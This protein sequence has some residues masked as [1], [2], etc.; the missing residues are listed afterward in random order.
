[1]K[2]ITAMVLC[3]LMIFSLVP[4][5]ITIPM[6]AEAATQSEPENKTALNKSGYEALGFTNLGLSEPGE[7]IFGPGGN[8]VMYEQKE[9][10]F[11]YNGSSNYGKVLRDN[12]NL[13]QNISPGD[14]EAAGAMYFYGQYRNDDWSHLNGGNGYTS[15]RLGG[16]NTFIE[17]NTNNVHQNLAYSTSVEFNNGSGKNDH[18]ARL[19]MYSNQK[20]SE[21][22]IVIEIYTYENNTETR[23]GGW[24]VSYADKTAKSLARAGEWRNHEFDSLIEVTA[25]DYDGDGKDEVAVYA[26]N[27]EIKIYKYNDSTNRL[28]TWKT[29][30]ASTLSANSG[31][32]KDADDELGSVEMAAVVTMAS[33]DLNKDYTDELAIAVS[34]PR[35]TAIDKFRSNNNLFVYSLN[36]GDAQ[37]AS[38][39]KQ[40]SKISL[41]DGTNSMD[42]ANV[43]IGDMTG[44]GHKELV[45]AGWKAEGNTDRSSTIMALHVEYKRSSKTYTANSFQTIELED[46]APDKKGSTALYNAPPGVAV[47]NMGG[48]TGATNRVY[49]FINNFLYNYNT[50]TKRYDQVS[51]GDI[52][53]LTEQRNNADEKTDKSET[54]ISKIV[55]GNFSG[56]DDGKEAL[57]AVIGQKESGGDAKEHWYYY[58][59][60]YIAPNGTDGFYKGCE[61][62]I[63]QA[64]SYIDRTDISRASVFLDLCSPNTDDDSLLL[65]YK[66]AEAY[67]TKPEVQAILQSAPYFQDVADSFDNYLDDGATGYG[68]SKGS[69]SGATA[70]VSAALGAYTETEVQLGGAGQFELEVRATVSYDHE[71]SLEVTTSREFMGNAGDDYVVMYTIPYYR[72]WYD[73]YEPSTG[74]TYEMKI[75][76][77]LTPATVIVPVETYDEIADNY[78]GLEKIRGNVLINTPG[79][80]YS[81]EEWP[82]D[83]FEAIGD[84]QM[85]TNA[86]AQSG[87]LVTVSRESVDSETNSFSVGVE[88]NLK[89]GA[90]GG[91]FG[92]KSVTG[93]S[94]SLSVAGGG[95]FSDMSGVAYTGSVDNLPSGVSGYGFNW[96]F[97][98][99]EIEFNGETVIVVG[100]QTSNVKSGPKAPK[101]LN[102]TDIGSTS[103]SLEWEGTDDASIYEVA[104]VTNNMELP[105]ATIPATDVEDDGMVR[106]TAYELSPNRQYTFRVTAANALGVRSVSGQDAVGTTLPENSGNFMITAQPSDTSAAPGHSATFEVAASSTNKGPIGYH[107]QYYD[108]TARVWTPVGTNSA[109]LSIV[110]NADMDGT[111]YR[112]VVYQGDYFLRTK[113]V[114]LT[115]NKSPTVTELTIK[116]K[117]DVLAE[118]SRVAANDIR[119][120]SGNVDVER[121][122][123][124]TTTIDGTTYTRY[125]TVSADDG[126]E[127]YV[128]SDYWLK[129]GTDSEFCKINGNTIAAVTSKL[130]YQHTYNSAK[131]DVDVEAVA[132]DEV[133]IKEAQGEGDSATAAVKSTS[134]YCSADGRK[135][136]IADDGKNYIYE[137]GTYSE[138]GSVAK[139]N[140]SEAT[141]YL[142][143]GTK[144]TE[145]SELV[146]YYKS[147][148][149]SET[150]YTQEAVDGDVITLIS[151]VSS[152]DG[153]VKESQVV[154]SITNKETGAVESV[155]GTLKNGQYTA[156]HTFSSPG[157][158]GIVAIYTGSDTYITS[159]SDE[160]IIYATGC[161]DELVLKGGTISYGDS[162]TLVPALLKSDGTVDTNITVE[163]TNVA[164]ENETVNGLINGNI[165]RP[166]KA[167]VYAITAKYDEMTVTTLVNVECKELLLRPNDVQTGV[168]D[169]DKASKMSVDVEDDILSSG[170][171]VLYSRA[172]SAKQVGE[173]PITI[174]LT[175]QGKS[176]TGG[177]YIVYSEPGTY[178]LTTESYEVSASAGSNGNVQITYS[179]D[180][181][182]SVT[183]SSGMRV[184]E[185]STVIL[186]AQPDAGYG[187]NNWTIEKGTPTSVEEKA[188][189]KTFE[190]I[191]G[192][193]L[194]KVTFGQVFNT[195]VYGS[196]N[197]S[198][199]TV[200]GKYTD[201]SMTFVS[202]DKINI[203]QSVTLTATPA[204]GYVLAKWTKKDYV[205]GKT[206][207]IKNNDG[208]NYTG[209]TV[210]VSGVNSQIE[211]TA[212]FEEKTALA[213]TFTVYDTRYSTNVSTASVYVNDQALQRADN[214]KFTYN[215]YAHENVKIKVVIPANMLVDNWVLNG[216]SAHNSVSE[217]SINDISGEYDFVINCI[218]PNGRKVTM[219]TALE[220][221]NGGTTHG[222]SFTAWRTS[223]TEVASGSEQPQGAEIVFTAS[224]ADGY[225]VN[226]IVSVDADGKETKL[227]DT[228]I[229]TYTQTLDVALTL[230]AYFEKKPVITYENATENGDITVQSGNET[231]ACGDYVEFGSEIQLNI[232]PDAGYIV[233]T[234]KMTSGGQSTDVPYEKAGGK[235]DAVTIAFA[236]GIT[237]D[238]DFVV[239]YKKK[240]VITIDSS[241]GGK[242]KALGTKDYDNQEIASGSYVDFGSNLVLTLTPDEGYYLYSVV[243]EGTELFKDSQEVY[244][245]GE[246]TVSYEPTDGISENTKINVVFKAKP[247]ITVNP[248]NVTVTPK[249][250]T[251][252][253]TTTWIEKY[254]NDLTFKIVPDDGY[255]VKSVVTSNNT[256]TKPESA[257]RNDN[258][259][260]SVTDVI[261][262]DVVINVS[263]DP[264]PTI[265]FKTTVEKIDEEGDG[266]HGTVAANV[267]RKE[268]DFHT[269]L[270]NADTESD[271][272][273]DSVISIEA[274]PEEGYRVQSWTVN[275][276]VQNET[277]STLVLNAADTNLEVVVRFIK[278]VAGV[279]FGPTDPADSE[280]YISQAVAGDVDQLANASTGVNLSEGA[281]IYF[282]ATPAVGYEIDYWM[283]NSAKAE[284]S[285]GLESYEYTSL[286]TSEN[287]YIEP[288]FVQIE[289]TV[290]AE[291]SNGTIAI[292]PSLTDNKA[293]GGDTLTFTVTPDS[294]YA[295]K[296]WRVNGEDVEGESGS[297][298]IWTVP[299]GA[300]ANPEVSE[301]EIQAVM[302]RGSYKIAYSSTDNG[303]VS[304]TTENGS[305]VASGTEVKVVANPAT[306]YHLDHWKVNGRK[307][308]VTESEI[309]VA[310]DVD[311]TVEAVFAIDLIAVTFKTEGN[312]GNLTAK[313]NGK[314]FSSGKTVEYGSEVV[315]T[316][317]PSGDDMISVWKVNGTPIDGTAMTDDA[318]APLTYTLGSITEGTEISVEFIDRPVYKV[319]AQAIGNGIVEI[320]G[321][322]DALGY[323]EV[324]RGEN[325]KITATAD[326]YYQIKAWSVNG[327][328]AGS[329]NVYV[330][331][332]VKKDTVVEAEFMEAVG[333]KVNFTLN[334]SSTASPDIKVL[335]NGV[336]IHP[337]S[338]DADAVSVIGGKSV[339]VKVEPVEIDSESAMMIK[340]WHI[341][342]TPVTDEN[343][344]DFGIVFDDGDISCGL[345][346]TKLLTNA[347][348]RLDIA[349]YEGIAIPA[350]GVGY[351]VKTISRTPSYTKPETE[352]VVGGDVEFKVVP[353][354]YMG[355]TKL[356]INGVDCLTLPQDGDVTAIA[357]GDGSYTIS[358][359]NVREINS[360]I[361]ALHNTHTVTIETPI[362]GSISV[363]YSGVSVISGMSVPA[364]TELTITAIPSDGFNIRILKINGENFTSGSTYTIVEDIVITSTFTR[365][366]SGG[367]GG[368]GGGGGSAATYTVKFETNG[369]SKI[370]NVK[371]AKNKLIEKPQ[372]P[373]RE[374]Y[375]FDGWYSDEQLQ[376]AYDF[377]TKVTK[378]ITLYAKWTEKS[379]GSQQEEWINPF[380]DVD[381]D[382]WF[383]ENVR[384]TNENSLMNGTSKTTFAPNAVITR[385]MLIT[386][387]YRAEGEPDIDKDSGDAGFEDV[388]SK[389]YYANAVVWGQ[390]NGIIKGYSE[391]EFAPDDNVTRE[392][393]AAI[394]HRYAQYKKYDVST[395]KDSNI[396][397]YDDYESISEYAIE[398][399]KYAVSNN[400][401]RGK[402]ESTLNPSDSATRAEVAA[403]LNRFIEANVQKAD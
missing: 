288:H 209:T 223:G 163:Y 208:T 91:L 257:D 6:R 88:E 13:Y 69:S 102:I 97:G 174:S 185:G 121:F 242:A 152:D 20:R 296:K 375:I 5:G 182:N 103:M 65:K 100:Y 141:L 193:I 39:F 90:G 387:I 312:S 116:N 15:G 318:D 115:I 94:Q 229:A 262:Q 101:N 236:D 85:L 188:S 391:T 320:A 383:Y 93:V 196:N 370:E 316:A 235:S 233:D 327:T 33:G 144:Y 171:Y 259:I 82:L 133:T 363:D 204:N 302:D 104:I 369:G 87:S 64:R 76:E 8:T 226:R 384:Y 286:G 149:V 277:S 240:P 180:G 16:S 63:N 161:S 402:T 338:T 164:C 225:R 19:K 92:N 398:S 153:T 98:I 68:T 377:N 136:Y 376:N 281:T 106:F 293:R 307:Q 52:E 308:Q 395:D 173:Y 289:Y 335:A 247:T 267:T 211:Y 72:Y 67:Y 53:F 285:E 1:M 7:D 287:V 221:T 4:Q 178:T 372:D 394:M 206:E 268:L 58:S 35:E 151:K 175:S 346:I 264:I 322:K 123:T 179:I 160:T 131:F 140:D 251:K 11:N 30:S 110:T 36:R 232:A 57:V 22:S 112:C 166:D 218:T 213:M 148:T 117:T 275:G 282:A 241:A 17:K 202:G 357:N 109:V 388:D 337:G 37:S 263:A 75:E 237:L 203:A 150:Q 344:A 61:G 143:D 361:E 227:T 362:N 310:V 3:V 73:A 298:L 295:V 157:V 306:G 355:I 256:T 95:V 24:Y 341:N 200:S 332:G 31:L 334:N 158:Y 360:E 353:D 83:N 380:D 303:S 194:A 323:V 270:I 300:A 356:T 122:V 239:T 291:V 54:W 138:F 401:L 9:L 325:V 99:S 25:G 368:G 331:A 59:I 279:S 142:K 385:A 224:P 330:V 305:Y 159:R 358:L 47:V 190:N 252:D 234:V 66:G 84:V 220:A 86:G 265:T 146:V 311:T 80:P 181:G 276:A 43:A 273:R 74:K 49:V 176:K 326:E 38:N 96:Q 343:A 324:K 340:Q 250:G 321:D 359:K 403:I 198:W 79:D 42:S 345:T 45:V 304:S 177:K 44:N 297:T 78:T 50:G 27:N 374:D 120:V 274:T 14:L 113:T 260:V 207:I 222:S 292:T 243:A 319:S 12:V 371:V 129:N 278:T 169:T 339:S 21:Q 245:G 167:G 301:Y 187:V 379:A 23:K 201:S 130:L 183:I 246:E 55:T 269:A 261:T 127:T 392:Q 329:E 124:E 284:G 400:I 350:D 156:E 28:S 128:A 197:D 393:I 108:E 189:T 155:N 314:S 137:N 336:Q 228:G 365:L 249:C 114:T 135:I 26:A 342:G 34:M 231:I 390:K 81:Y 119:T 2:R 266:Y 352:I 397:L 172:T 60:A 389:A 219:Q 214:G 168:N 107:W 48:L 77:P 294:G 195:L 386:V 18:V 118:G 215:G 145:V 373:Q 139:G 216:K 186:I 217:I 105:L 32:Y 71:S 51:G 132:V 255:E 299:N 280:G 328:Q 29:I 170:D 165:F 62:V 154:F 290:K 134:A 212:E 253:V 354:E 349:P 238:T 396:H 230:K 199:G 272:C 205:T 126:T 378:S 348:I 367:G 366:S 258:Q 271:V 317:V 56:S 315:F 248:T 283:I 184:P 309:T 111:K 89:V 364:G 399:M 191:T 10:L 347:H 40:I 41:S 210:N 162:L 147:A 351:S 46:T 333:Y 313:Y 381:D 125:G 244:T 70:S 192:D 382:D 254:T